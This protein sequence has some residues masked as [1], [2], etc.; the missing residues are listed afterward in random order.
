MMCNLQRI[1][2]SFKKKLTESTNSGLLWG[3]CEMCVRA[4]PAP[5]LGGSG[6]GPVVSVGEM[7]VDMCALTQPHTHT[8][9]LKTTENVKK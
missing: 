1:S 9:M 7:C 6:A 2:K 4:D 5:C 8:M 3:V